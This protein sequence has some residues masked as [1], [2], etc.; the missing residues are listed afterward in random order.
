M[1]NALRIATDQSFGM[2]AAVRLRADQPAAGVVKH[3]G[4]RCSDSD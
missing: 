3:E 4:R 2:V 1:K